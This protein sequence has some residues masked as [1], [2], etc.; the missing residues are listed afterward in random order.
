M[1]GAGLLDLPAEVL[2][3]ILSLL[4]TLSLAAVR[5]ACRALRDAASKGRR[6]LV[7]GTERSYFQGNIYTATAHA[8][9]KVLQLMHTF[10]L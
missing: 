5:L 7:I 2:H 1:Q 10:T 8:T 6:H 4:G 9:P 3:L